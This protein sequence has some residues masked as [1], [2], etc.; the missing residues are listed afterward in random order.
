[1]K[2]KSKILTTI[3]IIVLSVNSFGAFGGKKSN[4]MKKILAVVERMEKQQ[5]AMKLE[6]V[7]QTLEAIEQTQK[8]V[9]MVQNDLTN[10]ESWG[11]LVLGEENSHILQTFDELNSINK[12]TQ[13]ILRNSKNIESNFD[14]IYLTKD[15]IAS[16][17][18]KE[19]ANELYRITKYKNSNLKEHLK[20]ASVILEQNEKDAKKM[21]TFM[22]TTDEAKGNLQASLATKKG[23]DQL[24]TKIARLT[25]VQAKSIII[26]TEK[27]AEEEAVNQLLDEQVKRMTQMNSISEKKANKMLSSGKLW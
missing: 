19:L 24:N 18:S 1:M 21:S 12:S 17:D 15:K 8:Q 11:G 3:M 25:D 6:D 20:T 22:A 23:V 2:V 4:P 14:K 10:L 27:L 16:M 26:Q 13:S 9:E 7:K 5:T